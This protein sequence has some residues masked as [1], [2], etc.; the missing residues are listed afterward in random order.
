MIAA[1]LGDTVGSVKSALL[2]TLVFCKLCLGRTGQTDPDCPRCLGD[3]GEHPGVD[4][5][6]LEHPPYTGEWDDPGT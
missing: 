3:K 6:S 5:S 1:G 2:S 4:P